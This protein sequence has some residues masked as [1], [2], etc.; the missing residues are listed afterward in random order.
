LEKIGSF[1]K[2]DEIV[3]EIGGGEGNLT[4]IL[5]RNSKLVICFEIDERKFN[6]LKKN[7]R[8]WSYNKVRF[9]SSKTRRNLQNIRKRERSSYKR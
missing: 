9:P 3:L 7:N 8:I 6:H 2:N 4:K 1:A 5:E